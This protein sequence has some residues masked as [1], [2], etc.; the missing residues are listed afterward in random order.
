MTRVT[1][2][3]VELQKECFKAMLSCFNYQAMI[4]DSR[5]AESIDRHLHTLWLAA[6]LAALK[7]QN[8]TLEDREKNG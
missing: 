2:P 4:S 1:E 5:P 7:M 8:A 3:D 6:G